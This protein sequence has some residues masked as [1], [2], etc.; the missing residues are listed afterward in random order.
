M[1]LMIVIVVFFIVIYGLVVVEKK[2]EYKFGFLIFYKIVIFYFLYDYSKGELFVVVMIIVVER[3]N[4]DLIFLLDYNLIFVW[5]DIVC[6][7]F[8]VVWE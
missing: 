1:V 4:V 3:V 2:W 7:E 8:V 5:K 6:N